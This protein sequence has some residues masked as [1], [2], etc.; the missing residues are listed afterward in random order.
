[1]SQREFSHWYHLYKAAIKRLIHLVWLYFKNMMKENPVRDWWWR[2]IVDQWY[3]SRRAFVS[4]ESD[5]SAKDYANLWWTSIEWAA[6]LHLAATCRYPEGGR[7]IDVQQCLTRRGR[8]MGQNCPSQ[9]S[10]SAIRQNTSIGSRQLHNK[11]RYLII[12]FGV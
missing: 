4:K 7:L 12:C 6:N 8:K 11:S 9:H 2:P 10:H 1:M 5:V 3:F